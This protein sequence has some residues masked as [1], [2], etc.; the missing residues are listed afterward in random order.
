[1]TKQLL[2]NM[3]I[4]SVVKGLT[5]RTMVHHLVELRCDMPKGKCSCHGQGD[6]VVHDAHLADDIMK[7]CVHRRS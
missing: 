4:V 1:M 5:R 6:E 7:G 3:V 2:N